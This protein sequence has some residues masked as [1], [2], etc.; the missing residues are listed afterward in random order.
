M[1]PDPSPSSS[2]WSSLSEV[3]FL[4][5]LHFIIY[6]HANNCKAF[7]IAMWS[8]L[9]IKKKKN[10]G[11]KLKF[12]RCFIDPSIHPD[13]PP[14]AG[15][16]SLKA[17]VTLSVTSSHSCCSIILPV[18]VTTWPVLQHQCKKSRCVFNFQSFFYRVDND[19]NRYVYER[20]K[21]RLVT[22]EVWRQPCH[23]VLFT[24][25]WLTVNLQTFP[26]PPVI[27]TTATRGL[28][29]RAQTLS[30]SLLFSLCNLFS[31]FILSTSVANLSVGAHANELRA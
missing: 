9:I 12:V 11:W 16:C 20:Q 6:V 28:Y 19:N 31:Y 29:T 30:L 10:F 21:W 14:S 25:Q 1:I 4:K 13:P 24:L 5:F 8:L 23:A 7:G 22:R 3:C 2:C 27:I 26:F 18:G 17:L 15:C